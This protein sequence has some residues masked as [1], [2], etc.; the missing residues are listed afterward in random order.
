MDAW[1]KM[2][3]EEMRAWVV[4]HGPYVSRI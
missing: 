3:E 1:Y 2:S 4:A